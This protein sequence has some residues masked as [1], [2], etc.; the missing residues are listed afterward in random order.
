M[1]LARHGAKVYLAA[2]S[3]IRAQEAIEKLYSEIPSLEKGKIVW[4]PLDLSDLKG[5]AAAAET[6]CKNET[7][8][9]ILSTL[10]GNL[11]G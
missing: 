5:V 8:L 9:D 6:I 2:R 11:S 3:E 10:T 7:R 4:L 1:Q